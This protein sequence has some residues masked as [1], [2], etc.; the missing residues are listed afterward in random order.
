MYF[1]T[2]SKATPQEKCGKLF[3]R[4]DN[5]AHTQWRNMKC[6]KIYSFFSP[7]P[8]SLECFE[9]HPRLNEIQVDLG[10]KLEPPEFVG[11]T[12]D[13][14]MSYDSCL[15]HKDGGRGT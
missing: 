9:Q 13:I 15:L 3:G 10:L 7:P 11:N 2:D 14:S 12:T 1:R 8:L 4:H 6:S 5:E